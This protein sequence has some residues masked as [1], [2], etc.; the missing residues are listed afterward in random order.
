MQMKDITQIDFTTPPFGLRLFVSMGLT[1]KGL[2]EIA[3]AAAP[4]TIILA[5]VTLL[6]ALF[7]QI[8]LWLPNI[9]KN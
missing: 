4:Y 5:I 9:L 2:W 1:K 6:A 3:R 7:P 8:A